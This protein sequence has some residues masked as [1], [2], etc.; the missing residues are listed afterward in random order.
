MRCSMLAET[1]AVPG[2][3]T[4]GADGT[5]DGGGVSLLYFF[6]QCM[7][8][9][10]WYPLWSRPHQ[11]LAWWPLHTFCIG[12]GGRMS[13]CVWT[14]RQGGLLQSR[15]GLLCCR[16]HDLNSPVQHPLGI[17]VL[18]RGGRWGWYPPFCVKVPVGLFLMIIIHE[19]LVLPKLS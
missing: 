10:Q 2:D 16:Q 14:W 8:M 6:Q 12:P 15:R 19:R 11:S 17:L 3:D 1:E 5:E 13:I 4:H 18:P 9:C 7:W